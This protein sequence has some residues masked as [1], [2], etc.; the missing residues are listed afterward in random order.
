MGYNIIRDIIAPWQAKGRWYRFFIES[1]GENYHL[2]KSPLEGSD[3]SS[4]YLRLPIGYHIIDAKGDAHSIGEGTATNAVFTT[5][6]FTN[7]QQGVLLPN[8]NTFSHAY[9]WVFAYNGGD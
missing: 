1:D 6:L 5:K 3:I 2:T 4:N 7:G 8:K 9:V